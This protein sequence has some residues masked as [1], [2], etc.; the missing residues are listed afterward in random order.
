VQALFAEYV[1]HPHELPEEFQEWVAREGV[2]RGVC[3]YIAGMTDRYAPARV[4]EALSPLRADLRL[5]SS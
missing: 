2:H 1:K 4:R 3:D 5:I